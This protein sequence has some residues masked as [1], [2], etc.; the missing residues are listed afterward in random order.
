MIQSRLLAVLFPLM[1]WGLFACGGGQEATTEGEAADTEAADDAP[2]A[3]AQSG[4]SMKMDQ[5]PL[6]SPESIISDGTY[7]YV[8]NV[9][10]KLEPSTKDGDGF[11]M[12]L[13]DEGKVV[14]EKFMTG[15]DAPKGSA[16]VDGKF[17][18]ADID[19]VRI[20][21]LETGEAAG[22]IDLAKSGTAFLNDLTPM[23]KGKLAVSAT[24]VN[25]IYTINLAENTYEELI[26]RPT[27]TGPN[28]LWYDGD[29]QALYVVNYLSE[30]K[31]VLG[32]VNLKEKAMEGDAYPYEQLNPFEGTL[33]G[34]AI[35]GDKAFVSDWNR[36]SIIVMDL[37]TGQVGGFKLPSPVQ[38]PA[39]FYLDTEKGEIW[40]PGMMENTI[41]VQTL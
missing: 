14:T 35:Y 29:A 23:G 11:I 41:T 36:Q 24:D 37:N 5:L 16:I 21:D 19:K 9:G 20:F 22:M 1:A 18:V 15:L 10:P 31:G 26:T 6:G 2:R 3:M 28:G 30:P 13:D 12:K 27:I 39:D 7:Y 33:D 38:G 4:R 25:R 8:S 17:Y 34:L 32:M 40:L